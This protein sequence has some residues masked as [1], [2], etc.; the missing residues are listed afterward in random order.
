M[1]AEI[2]QSLKEIET[3]ME[4]INILLPGLPDDKCE[5]FLMMVQTAE[6]SLE[7]AREIYG[8]DDET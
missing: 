6:S 5:D 3:H 7:Q 8:E 2:E 1:I 4:N